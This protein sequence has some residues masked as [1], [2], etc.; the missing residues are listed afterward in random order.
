MRQADPTAPWHPDVG[1]AQSRY[2]HWHMWVD[3]AG[4]DDDL[5]QCGK[6]EFRGK[7]ISR[8]RTLLFLAKGGWD[9]ERFYK[10]FKRSECYA[11][12]LNLEETAD[13]TFL[14]TTFRVEARVCQYI[15]H[16]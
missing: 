5:T 12:P 16:N 4:V 1:R 15:I 3:G 2:D 13:E 9:H 14:E 10:D 11:R 8:R 6:E 7:A